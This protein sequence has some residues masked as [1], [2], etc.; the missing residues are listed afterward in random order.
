MSFVPNVLLSLVHGNIFPLLYQ[1]LSSYGLT[2]QYLFVSKAT[3][4]T[5]QLTQINGSASHAILNE[6]G[7]ASII[8]IERESKSLSV[9]Q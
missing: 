3:Q 9:S 7:Y 2:V 6:H 8:G 5:P 1:W 4:S